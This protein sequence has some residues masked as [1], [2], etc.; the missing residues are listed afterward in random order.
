MR[1][2]DKRRKR[3]EV[4]ALGCGKEDVVVAEPRRRFL[5]IGGGWK[6]GQAPVD[7]KEKACGAELTQD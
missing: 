5:Q 7:L 4:V 6:W 3:V 2:D 1:G